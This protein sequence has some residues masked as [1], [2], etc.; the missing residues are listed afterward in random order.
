LITLGWEKLWK[1]TAP[2][3]TNFDDIVNAHGGKPVFIVIDEG[4]IG[5]CSKILLWKFVHV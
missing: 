3:L 5:F 1:Q 2:N 4:Q